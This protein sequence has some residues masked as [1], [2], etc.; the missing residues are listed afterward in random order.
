MSRAPAA[1][2]TANDTNN[3]EQASTYAPSIYAA[4]TY[5]P[6]VIEEES[7]AAPAEST[8]A[9]SEVRLAT[10]PPLIPKLSRPPASRSSGAA[11]FQQL[12][13]IIRG[14]PE[15]NE[16]PTAPESTYAESVYPEVPSSPPSA[17]PVKQSRHKPITADELK[18]EYYKVPPASRRLPTKLYNQD[19]GAK[20]KT[21]A[22][23]PRADALLF[24]KL[25][26]SEQ[27]VVLQVLAGIYFF[28]CNAIQSAHHKD[29]LPDGAVRG[30]FDCD[31]TDFQFSLNEL[32]KRLA[33]REGRIYSNLGNYNF[34][35]LSATEINRFRNWLRRL[36]SWM[37]PVSGA[38][39]AL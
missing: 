20:Y 26:N 16:I 2:D 37:D 10:P 11:G 6:S 35:S 9:P 39:H 33:M 30:I 19:C 21:V 8:Y 27:M 38:A 28:R 25:I 34:W 29:S 15:V 1:N 3:D 23:I 22:S 13:S 32:Y 5:A 12:I 31:I 24:E 17:P 14:V 36:G 4:S 7:P 18:A